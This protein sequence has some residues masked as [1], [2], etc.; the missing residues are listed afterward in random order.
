MDLALSLVEEDWGSEVAS[1]AAKA[2]LL[3]LRRPGGQSQ[4][5]TYIVNEAKTRKDFRELQA[6]MVSHPEQDLSVER[7]AERMVMSPRNFSRTF[8][9]EIGTPPGKFVER[10]RLEAAKQMMSQTDLPL[11]TVACNCGFGTAEQMRRTFQR[12]IKTS[13]QAHRAYFKVA[14]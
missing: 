4:F 8:C 10:L 11:E 7:L 6:W 14:G 9:Q 12:L 5:S 3:F 1:G 2:M 13:P